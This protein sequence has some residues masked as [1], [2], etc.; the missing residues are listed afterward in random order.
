MTVTNTNDG[1]VVESDLAD[2]S[3]AEDA[4]FTLDASTVFSD[5]DLGDVLTYSATLANGD[6]LPA[7]LSIDP[8]TGVLSGTPEN[9]DVG[10]LSVVVTASDGEL[11]VAADPF[12]V[13]VT[14]TNDG[15]VVV[16]VS[17]GTGLEGEVIHGDV[18]ATDVDVG[19]VL[20]YSFGFNTDG[21]P[22][23]TLQTANG[24]V[25]LDSAS[26][27]YTFTPTD[28]EFSGTDSFQVTVTDGHGGSA[29][30][31]VSVS[32]AEVD[33][34]TQVSGNVELADGSEDVAMFISTSSLLANASDADDT[35]TVGNLVARDA[36]GNVVGTFEAATVDGEAGYTFTPA[37]NYSGDVTITYDVMPADGSGPAVS[38]TATLELAGVADTPDLSV[39]ADVHASGGSEVAHAPL[40]ISAAVTDSSESLTVTLTLPAGVG[41]VDADGN[42]VG[43]RL[44]DNTV[45]LT[46]DEANADGLQLEIPR[47]QDDFS[48]GVT[49]TSVD[50]TDSAAATATIEV[51]VPAW[52]QGPV[53]VDDSTIDSVAQAAAL[54]VELSGGEFTPDPNSGGPGADVFTPVGDVARVTPV[55][56]VDTN[57]NMWNWQNYTGGSGDDSVGYTSFGGYSGTV[58]LGDGNNVLEVSGDASTVTAGGGNDTVVIGGT[59]NQSI[60]LGGGNNVLDVGGNTSTVT[61]GSGADTIRVGGTANQTISMGDGN[62]RLDIAGNAS[63][64]TAGSGDDTVRIG[65]EANKAIN[66]G[67]GDNHLEIHGNANESIATGGGDDTIRIDGVQNKVVTLGGGD[68]VLQVGGNSNETVFAGSGD[69]VVMLNGS[70]VNKRVDMG[71]DNDALKI[72]GKVSADYVD[73]GSGTDM[74]ELGHYSYQ[75]W[76][77]GVD[78]ISSRVRN[79]EYIKFND[80]TVIDAA[81]NDV[82]NSPS[83]PFN[84]DSDTGTYEYQLDVTATLNDADGSE[85]LSA[86]TI[87][88]LPADAVLMQGETVLVPV[89]GVYTVD[90]SSGQETS[91]TLITTA[92]LDADNPGFTTSVTTT[93]AHGG[94][95]ETTVVEGVGSVSGDVTADESIRTAEDTALTINTADLLANDS[96]ADGDA[97]SV[98]GVSNPAHG[99]VV[100][101]SDGTITFT[102]DPDY[103]GEATFDYTISDGQ[104]GFSTATVTIQVD[105]VIDNSAPVF[106]TTSVSGVEDHTITGS[107]VATDADGDALTYALAE[108]GGP[109]HG[110]LTLN[111]DGSYS[112]A[113]EANWSGTDSFTVT[114]DDGEGGTA[115]QTITVNVAPDADTPTLAVAASVVGNA[116]TVTNMGH[117]EAAYHNT[118]GYYVLDADGNPTSGQIIWGD[119]KDTIGDSFTISGVNPERVGFFLI[120]DGDGLNGSKLTNGETV[121]FRQDANGNWQVIDQQGNALVGSGG[122]NVVFDRNELNPGDVD[123]VEDNT[124]L[125]GNQNWEDIAGSGSDWDYDDANFNVQTATAG[126]G[127]TNDVV[128]GNSYANTLYGGLGNDTVSGGGGNDV[129]Y[130]DNATS[131][132]SGFEGGYVY[133]DLEVDYGSPDAGET[134]TFQ[135]SGLPAGVTLVADGVAL[136]PVNGVVNLTQAQLD[137]LQVKIPQSLA[138]TELE[139]NFTVTTHDGTDTA[140]TTTLVEV[141]VPALAGDGND[142]VDGG[143][144]N[145]TIYGGGG[146]DNLFGGADNDT[147]YGGDGSD[148][149]TGGAGADKLYGGDGNDT[150]VFTAEDGT[151]FQMGGNNFDSA[152]DQGGANGSGGTGASVDIGS[153]YGSDDTYFGGDGYDTLQL[154]DNNDFIHISNVD[155]VE[156]INAGAGNDVIDMN[157]SDG[158]AYNSFTL[159]GGSGNDTVFA[160]NGDDVLFGGSGNDFMSGNAGN[161]ILDGGSG[162][163]KLYGG[164]G[165]DTLDGGTGNDTL[166][167]GDGADTFLFDFGDGHD[168]VDGG[169]GCWTDTIDLSNVADGVTIAIDVYNDCHGDWIKTSDTNGTM[170]IGSN[171]SGEITLTDQNGNEQTIEFE[172]IEKIV[173]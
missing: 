92:P 138:G 27:E 146:N 9:G 87:A 98:V 128:T 66:L 106:Q 58:N 8:E 4:A 97:L 63:T 151:G 90:V 17:G 154:T 19:D 54:N 3:T 158:G 42:P 37:T 115:T 159:D 83:N 21:S 26:G 133:A 157:Y 120:P 150:F 23:T 147:I 73:G 18:D 81:G 13:T 112:Y 72:A 46:S 79:F 140:S 137:S 22:I 36:D 152:G 77:N 53:A 101:N 171:R 122:A 70:V 52:N 39:D 20:T 45:V 114:V 121:T 1:P 69:D 40:D 59:A 57:V 78:Q 111:A 82:T 71:E 149:L 144:G 170:D 85:S 165:N 126:G 139:F 94:A 172:N 29:T 80:G 84:G 166:D 141:D 109:S 51:D 12:T 155:S 127:G 28:P 167:G 35:L 130:G 131:S 142:Y 67:G 68:D 104:G 44:D 99:Q 93:E 11:S 62:N 74:L 153:H 136:T 107:I 30:A 10:E 56:D 119:V 125:V 32:L 145:D 148:V 5:P 61:T 124:D 102:P 50:G 95:T 162:A 88:G 33:D 31:D 16:D 47:G 132:S 161:D 43:A 129:L 24:T 76:Q 41:V 49:A 168:T 117:E 173:W 156:R 123:M 34:A 48:V 108:G 25:E 91:L 6:P 96:D 169:T 65:G 14:N 64:I 103:Y 118:Y 110:A 143:S 2:V 116:I 100:L 7:W 89:D 105:D 38:A 113:A 60:N 160:N 135:V 15:P 164:S 86:V 75:D 134:F 55:G 163:D